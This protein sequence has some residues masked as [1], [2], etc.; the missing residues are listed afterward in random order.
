MSFQL[1]EAQLRPVPPR[2]TPSLLAYQSDASFV[3]GMKTLHETLQECGKTRLTSQQTVHSSSISV[4]LVASWAAHC[5]ECK[6]SW[7]HT[8]TFRVWHPQLPTLGVL[9][10]DF[11]H[12][13]FLP[14]L[15]G[16]LSHPACCPCL[17]WVSQWSL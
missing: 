1:F 6:E 9:P 10:G 7:G 11:A 12:C 4:A 8:N 16:V 13:F 15:L 17:P 2:A 14:L 3:S 5:S